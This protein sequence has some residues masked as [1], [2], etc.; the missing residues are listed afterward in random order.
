MNLPQHQPIPRK[1]ITMAPA[2]E[3]LSQYTE[4]VE[5][6]CEECGGSGR[7]RGTL[8]NF[9][10]GTEPVCPTCQGR[11]TE[12]VVRNYLSEAFAVVSN[13]DSTRPVER[14]HLVAI[15][16]FAREHVSALIQLPEV[17]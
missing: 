5:I 10:N 1:P 2:L 11:S 8:D 16:R 6:E 12:T 3:S 7:D 15:V 9:L 17:A 14:A 13:P 4:T